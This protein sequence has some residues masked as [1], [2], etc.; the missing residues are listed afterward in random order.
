MSAATRQRHRIELLHERSL[1]WF[2]VR[3]VG[4]RGTACF[5]KRSSSRWCMRDGRVAVRQSQKRTAEVS[6]CGVSRSASN[7]A[8]EDS[9]RDLR[10]PR[11]ASHIDDCSRT[12]ACLDCRRFRRAIVDT[13]GPAAAR[14]PAPQRFSP[15]EISDARLR[16]IPTALAIAPTWRLRLLRPA[17][18]TQI[19][20]RRSIA[21]A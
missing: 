5:E 21:V 14:E 6:N 16:L 4:E 8:R 1:F 20:V 18:R 9:C 17:A 10:R 3:D 15:T 7:G 13:A 2:R 12:T 11:Y 19:V